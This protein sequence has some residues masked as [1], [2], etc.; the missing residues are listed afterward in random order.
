MDLEEI[1]EAFMELVYAEL[2]SDPDNCR[3]NRIIDAYD[4]AVD[5]IKRNRLLESDDF[6]P[7]FRFFKE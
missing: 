5:S 1:R 6:E 4:D 7:I 3:A 2:D